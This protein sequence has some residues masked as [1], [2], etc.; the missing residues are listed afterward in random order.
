MSSPSVLH[1]RSAPKLYRGQRAEK[2]KDGPAGYRHCRR[3]RHRPGKRHHPHRR[4][5]CPPRRHRP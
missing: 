4:R 3:R 1:Q 5:H 2:Q